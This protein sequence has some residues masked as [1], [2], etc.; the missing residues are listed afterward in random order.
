MGLL[1][2]MVLPVTTDRKMNNS[3][4]VLATM[5]VHI[6]EINDA[7]PVDCG[8]HDLEGFTPYIS[9]GRYFLVKDGVGVHV[10]TPTGG[11]VSRYL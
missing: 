9:W 4:K 5:P 6:A 10:S 11:E 7:K 8:P 1:G 3:F 2:R